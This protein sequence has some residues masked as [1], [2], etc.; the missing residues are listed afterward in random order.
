ME[1]VSTTSQLAQ[2]EQIHLH[3]TDLLS[4]F[5]RYAN[6]INVLSLDCFDTLLWRKTITPKDVFFDMQRKPNYQAHGLAAIHR[7]DAEKN[8]RYLMY[9]REGHYEVKLKDVYRIANSSLTPQE[10]DQLIEEELSTEIEACYAFPPVIELIRAAHSLGK[11]VIIVS[12]TYFDES[13]LRRL[14]SNV[15]PEDAYTAISQVFCSCEYKQPKTNGL[16][17]QVLMQLHEPAN[18]IFHLGDNLAADLEAARAHGMHGFQLIQ[19]NS[20]VDEFIR[21]QSVAANL[22]DGSIHHVRSMENPFRG[23]LSS[24]NIAIDKPESVIG[25]LSMGPIMYTFARYL[26]E[27]IE[28]LKK[29]GKRP[30]PLFLMRDAYLPYLACEAYAGV[31][32]GTCVRISRFSAIASSFRT[33]EDI[34]EYLSLSVESIAFETICRQLH[35]SE[36]MKQELIQKLV[37]AKDLLASFIRLI[38]ED[39]MVQH[40]CSQSKAYWHRLQQ[41][42]LKQVD[43]QAGDTVVFI[44]LG[45]AGRTQRALTAVFQN[46]MKVNTTG[47]YLLT[48]NVLEWKKTRAGLLDPAKY[49]DRI[50]NAISLGNPLL[51]ELCCSADNSVVDY[52]EMGNPIFGSCSA[53]S[54]QRTRTKLI[55]D[56]CLRFIREAKQFF[57]SVKTQFAFSSFSDLTVAEMARRTFFPTQME[58]DYLLQY[59][60]DVNRGT[61][62]ATDAFVSPDKELTSLRRQGLW[63]KNQSPYGLRSAN[64]EL[65]LALFAQQRYGFA[66]NLDDLSLRREE[67]LA[68]TS[69]I[70]QKINQHKI[71]AAPTHDGYFSW[72]FVVD[73][74]VTQAAILLGQAYQSFQIE[75]VELIAAAHFLSFQQPQF[76]YDLRVSAVFNQ[77]VE[78]EDN[79]VECLSDAAALTIPLNWQDKAEGRYVLRVVYRPII[80]RK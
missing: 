47:R 1:A 64:F 69:T 50:T 52:D 66:V 16:F 80:R 78:R 67:V 62:L 77:M 18:K 28:Q 34:E 22:I 76:T 75:S 46:E 36:A 37:G 31:S 25:Y 21:L 5:R 15:L 44:D 56:E 43:I 10:I 57:A 48:L 58:I 14:L 63:F 40:I 23:F 65:S 17:N 35:I 79:Y 49:D 33:K 54:E 42:L 61:D 32:L 45:Y 41:Y 19:F 3:A 6:H 24:A 7:I 53:T 27:E 4:V 9:V 39:K 73:R 71:A 13:Q 70:D 11:K 72:W 12:N 59:Q 29:E 38:L 30:K 51:E 8:A 2:P 20:T 68:L 26:H 74:R 60:H 55:Q